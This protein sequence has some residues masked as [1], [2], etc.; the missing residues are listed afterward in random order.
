[1]TMVAARERYVVD[2][3]GNRVGVILD[4]RDFERMLEELEELE[5]IRAYDRAKASGGEAVPFE[6]AVEEIEQHC[7]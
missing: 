7:Q 3:K 1:M 2:E 5:S 6:Q 4:I